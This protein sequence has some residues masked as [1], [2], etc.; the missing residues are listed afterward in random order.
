MVTK[1]TANQKESGENSKNGAVGDGGVDIILRKGSAEEGCEKMALKKQQSCMSGLSNE[2]GELNEEGELENNLSTQ[3]VE[4]MESAE[5]ESGSNDGGR[6]GSL[7]TEERELVVVTDTGVAKESD[8]RILDSGGGG[9]SESCDILLTDIKLLDLS[10]VSTKH[11]SPL[12]ISTSVLPMFLPLIQSEN[13]LVPANLKVNYNKCLAPG[14]LY[15]MINTI[16]GN[17]Y[18]EKLDGLK[19]SFNN[20]NLDALFYRM[21]KEDV[22]CGTGEKPQVSAVTNVCVYKIARNPFL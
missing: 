22:W 10:D 14:R 19:N 8:Q 6:T 1:T 16:T 13:G 2:S 9:D 21:D 5:A 12:V 17:A 20:T 11:S 4:L 3:P 7:R 15:S 18:S